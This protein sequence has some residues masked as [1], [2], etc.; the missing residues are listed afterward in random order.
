M[1]DRPIV[2]A[3]VVVAA[4]VV[5][6][7][8]FY[9]AMRVDW[10]EQYF[11][12]TDFTAYAI[13]ASP[14]RY[15]IFRFA[16]AFITCLV[17]AVTL[18]RRASP[19]TF[20]STMLVAGIHGVSTLGV[21]LIAWARSDKKQRH[22]RASIAL[23]RS[24]A[25]VGVLGVALLAAATRSQLSFVVPEIRDLGTTLW[26]AGLAAIGG[27]FVV[28]YSRSHGLEEG[29]LVNRALN[30]L[31][32]KFIAVAVDAAASANADEVLVL[33]VM[34]VENLQRPPWF[35]QLE[36]WKSRVFRDGTYGIMQVSSRKALS[37]EESIRLAVAERFASVNVRTPKGDLDY[38]AL[39]RFASHYNGVSTYVSTLSTAYYA[40][41]AL[42]ATPPS[43]SSASSPPSSSG[44]SPSLGL[45]FTDPRRRTSACSVGRRCHPPRHAWPWAA[46]E[47]IG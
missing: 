34:A 21:A 8:M 19:Y 32:T 39:K 27:A 12:T 38:E 15:A 18:D 9:V 28:Q 11:A 31:P 22:R 25:L 30:S 24:V 23:I 35:R 17:V 5:F 43:R 47:H 13:S 46:L 2:E 3:A 33:A 14:I 42:R 4:G 10:P 26:T 40:A 16:P 7:W 6:L 20:T 36:R 44:P 29:N 1:I 37:D 45:F 41:R